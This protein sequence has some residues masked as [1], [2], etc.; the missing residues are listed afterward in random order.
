MQ[1]VGQHR[2]T[3]YVDGKSAGEFFEP[4]ANPVFAMIEVSSRQRILAAQER[5]PHA[6]RDAVIDADFG[7]I[8][9]LAAGIAGHIRVPPGLLES[10]RVFTVPSRA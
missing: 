10:I 2:K 5:A 7:C 3:K 9:D 8:D 4:V 6:P 1:M